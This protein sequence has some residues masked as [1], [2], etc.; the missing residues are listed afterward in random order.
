MET[1]GRYGGE[2][3]LLVLPETDAQG[4]LACGERIRSR[5]ADEKFHVARAETALTVS[6]GIAVYRA[7]EQIHETLAR[8]DQAL[9]RAKRNG[10]NRIEFMQAKQDQD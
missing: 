7:D 2:E 9:Y 8:A 6:I 10:R 3:F 1:F 5:I 4:T